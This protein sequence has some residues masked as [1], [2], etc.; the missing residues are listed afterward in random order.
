M[1]VV[2]IITSAIAGHAV[3]RHRTGRA[4][5]LHLVFH[6]PISKAYFAKQALARGI[7]YT[8]VASAPHQSDAGKDELLYDIEINAFNLET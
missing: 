6:P 7:D 4:P 8:V 2:P 5:T 3:I 1:N